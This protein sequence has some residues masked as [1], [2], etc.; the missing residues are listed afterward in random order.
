MPR[1]LSNI[2]SRIKKQLQRLGAESSVETHRS[3]FSVPGSENTDIPPKKTSLF[4]LFLFASIFMTGMLL[5]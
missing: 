4:R 3:S 1:F 5:F 2:L